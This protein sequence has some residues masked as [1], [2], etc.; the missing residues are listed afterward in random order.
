V[1]YNN[2]S[3]IGNFNT[4]GNW[5]WSST[6]NGNA[7]AWSQRFSDGTQNHTASKNN[8]YLVR[9]ARRSP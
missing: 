9:C 1:M 5:Y 2:N 7:Y 3:S 4:S 6:E 8:N